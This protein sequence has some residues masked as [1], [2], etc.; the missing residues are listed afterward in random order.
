METETLKELHIHEP[1]DLFSAEKQI[2]KALPKMVRAASNVGLIDRFEAHLEQTMGPANRLEAILK[3][4]G[5][6]TRGPK[7]QGMRGVLKEAEEMVAEEAEEEVRDAELIASAR[8]VEHYEMAG[9]GCAR[10][11]DKLLGDDEGGKLLQLTY[12][13]ES[14]TDEQLRELAVTVINLGAMK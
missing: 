9:Y 5:Q 8:R 4:L 6:S 7:C 2:I 3:N 1:K 13:E 12:A 10:I 14:A 11:Y